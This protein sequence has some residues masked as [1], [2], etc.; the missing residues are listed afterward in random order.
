GYLRRDTDGTISFARILKTK[1]AQSEPVKAQQEETAEWAIQMKRGALERF[2]VNFEDRMRTPAPRLTVSALSIRAENV[3]NAANNRAKVRIQAT[4]NNKG[5]VLLAGA[6]G[7]RPVA[8]RFNVELQGIGLVPFQPYLTDQINLSMTSGQVGS[9][10]LLT[11]DLGATPAKVAYEG[12]VQVADFASVEKD[13][14]EDLLKWKS[15]D[16]GGVQFN[17]EPMQLRINEISLGEFYARLILG[18]DGKLNL[19]NL[20]AQKNSTN[21]AVEAKP[22]P[23]NPPPP[24]TPATSEQKPISIGKINLQNGNINYSDFF[25]KPNYSANLTSV[26]GTISELKPETPGDISLDAK[27]D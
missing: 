1:P 11:L 21:G 15:L 16:L 14:S 17:L 26:Q 25:I 12:G 3:S 18:A 9:K 13:A 20:A 19:Q 4:I 8:G 5:S 6:L 10:G 22:K 2:R 27:L 23:A 24:T 7:L